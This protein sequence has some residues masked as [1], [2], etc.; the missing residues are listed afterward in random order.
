MASAPAPRKYSQQALAF[1]N[2]RQKGI[3]LVQRKAVRPVKK[4]RADLVTAQNRLQL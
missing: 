2:Q 1:L 4:H 3:F